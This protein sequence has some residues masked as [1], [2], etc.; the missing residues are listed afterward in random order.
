MLLWLCRTCR[1]TDAPSR[2]GGLHAIHSVVVIIVHLIKFHVNFDAM[3]L[4]R[5]APQLSQQCP[6]CV[7]RR[8]QLGL[9]AF[10][11]RRGLHAI[12]S[13]V[14]MFDAMR[15]IRFAPQCV[16]EPNS[17]TVLR[18]DIFVACHRAHVSFNLAFDILV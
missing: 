15:L 12:H 3:R 17:A 2:Y 18:S 13:V 11:R 10:Q 1:A 9:H 5:F 8:G 14:V 7:R 16:R 6:R 4:I